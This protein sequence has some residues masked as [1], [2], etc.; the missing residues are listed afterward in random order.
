MT[1]RT[2]TFSPPDISQAE[3]DEV[4]DTLKSGWITTGPKTKQLERELASFIGVDRLVCVNSATAALEC[5]LRL[6][7]IGPG[8]EVIT[9]AYTYTASCSPICHVGATPILCDTYPNSY[10]LDLTSLETLITPRTKAIIAVDL[11]GILAN[12][13]SL[14]A[15]AESKASLFTPNS[16]LQSVL[17]RIA[18]IAD[19]AHSL[20]ATGRGV[21]S[22]QAADFTSFSFHAV[23]NFTTAEGGALCWRSG[24]FDDEELYRQTMLQSLHGQ[25]KD[26]L[27]KSQGASWEYDI[28]FPGWKCNMTDIQAALG[29]VQLKRYPQLL[30]NRRA[31]ISA[32]ERN[33][34]GHPVSYRLHYT[35]STDASNAS[36]SD[37]IARKDTDNSSSSGHL[38]MVSLDGKDR[39]FRDTLIEELASQGIPTNVHYKPLPL[40][41]AYQNLGF[42]PQKYPNAIAQFEKEITL[43]LHTLLSV[44]DVDYICETFLKTYYDLE[45]KGLQ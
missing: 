14:I 16:E 11:G 32:Y 44:D 29:L 35:D 41:T 24:A 3:I 28:M 6:L 2:L 27:A 1:Q 15:L 18:I 33:L 9:S 23:K 19:G 31:L 17:G 40:L 34:A 39:A 20:G 25:T 5:I 13:P 42:K 43:P 7:E 10:D 26:A 37:D 21:S 4:V 30:A 36:E 8:D 12:Y 22:G 45:A 38:M